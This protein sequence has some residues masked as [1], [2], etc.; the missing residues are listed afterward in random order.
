MFLT[1]YPY[2]C[3]LNLHDLVV[4]QHEAEATPV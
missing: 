3:L 1:L 4:G 2:N